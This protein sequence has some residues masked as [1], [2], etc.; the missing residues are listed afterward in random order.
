MLR[1]GLTGNIASGKSAAALIFTELGAHVIDADRVAHELYKP[2]TGAYGRILAAFGKQ[3]LDSDGAIDRKKLGKIVFS[4]AEKRLQLNAILHPEV[5]AAIM[6][7]IFELEEESPRGM[8]IVDA[9]LMVETGGYKMY[10]RLIVVSCSLSIQ[11]SRLMNRDGMTEA[12][13]RARIASQLPIEEKLKLAD[14]VID[15]SGTLKQTR[16]QVEKIYRDL[17]ALEVRL[18]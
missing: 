1:V 11:I 13:A 12:D 7:R 9:A 6:R 17:L 18:A 3:I 4:D 10:D 8:I 14:Y 2:G 5:G 16:D 15:T